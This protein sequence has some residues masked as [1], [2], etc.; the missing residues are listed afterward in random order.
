MEQVVI[1]GLSGNS[2]IYIGESIDNLSKYIP[3]ENVFIITDKNVEAHYGS[4]FPAFPVY[5]IEPGE[6]SK[7][8]I[9]ATNVFRWL[10]DKGADRSSFIV[11]I[12]GGVVSDLA[13]F[14][15]STYMRGI[16]F[17]FVATTLLSQVD[18]SVGGK[19]GV[20]LDGFKN[21]VGTFNQPQFVICDISTLGTLHRDE[22]CN[23]L[24]EV[25]KH[26]LIYDADKFSFL[27]KNKSGIMAFNQTIMTFLVNRSVNIKADIVTAD[28]RENGI[29]RKLNLGHT[30]GHAVEKVTGMPHGQAV[31]IGMAFSAGFSLKKGY[32]GK[33][34]HDRIIA[35]LTDLG[36][37]IVTT[38]NPMVIFETLLR[39]KKKEQD[40]IH[41]VLMEG[42]GNV[43]VEL[44]KTDEIK[45]FANEF[46]Q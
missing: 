42:I 4:R 11:G 17:G 32:L 22:Y 38:A 40:G 13:G 2:T 3:S 6:G 24:A 1:N 16:S 26:A 43:K 31:S 30:W 18:A 20:N 41:F 33:V 35:L 45:A 12:G 14:V 34:E 37:P 39:D 8:F 5:T 28:E 25:V 44:L 9:S 29:R 15:A 21:I 19:N 10:L 23:G 27:E 7:S 46:A 36:L